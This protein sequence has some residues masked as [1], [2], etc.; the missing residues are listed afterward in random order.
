MGDCETLYTSGAT[1]IAEDEQSTT[2]W[3]CRRSRVAADQVSLS[4]GLRQNPV[5]TRVQSRPSGGCFAECDFRD[6]D[7]LVSLIQIQR[8]GRRSQKYVR[9]A[10]PHLNT[11]LKW[12]LCPAVILL[13]FVLAVGFLMIILSCALWSNWLPLLVGSLS[14]PATPRYPDPPSPF[15]DMVLCVNSIDLRNRTSSQ[16]ALLSLR[17]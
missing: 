10:L 1:M 12:I 14:F 2:A 15:A 11:P 6:A 4:S 16:R 3:C 5:A 13:S 17:G 9:P 8:H 7:E